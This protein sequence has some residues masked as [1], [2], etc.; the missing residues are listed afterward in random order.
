MKRLILI[1]L[2]FAGIT[3]SQVNPFPVNTFWKDSSGMIVPKNNKSTLYFK[4]ADTTAFNSKTLT[5]AQ[6]S[7]KADTSSVLWKDS[8]GVLIPKNNGTIKVGSFLYNDEMQLLLPDTV[9]AVNGQ[10]C[11]I[12]FDNV[13][14][15]ANW[16]NYRYDVICDSGIQYANRW[17]WTPAITGTVTL[18]LTINIY[19][20]THLVSTGNTV[21]KANVNS[22]IRTVLLTGNSLT[23]Q[24]TYTQEL[25]KLGG[26]LFKLLGTQGSTTNIV[27]IGDTI[28]NTTKHSSPIIIRYTPSSADTMTDLSL[29][30]DGEVVASSD[31]FSVLSTPLTSFHKNLDSLLANNETNYE[32]YGMLSKSVWDDSADKS[33]VDIP[34]KTNIILDPL[35]H[36]YFIWVSNSTI[37][38]YYDSSIVG[39][40]YTD[41]DLFRLEN[42]WY[43][44]FKSSHLAKITYKIKKKYSNEGRGGWTYSNY[45]NGVTSP[46]VLNGN[47][48]FG[49]YLTKYYYPT[50][51]H[52][53]IELGINDIFGC[54]DANIVATT[55]SILQYADSLVNSM[56]TAGVTTIGISYIM[57]PSFSQDAFASNYNTLYNTW[58]YKKNVHYFNRML[59]SHFLG[60][61]NVSLIPIQCNID[62]VNNMNTALTVYNA[63]NPNTYSMQ[64]NG[65]H[66]NAYGYWQMA[67]SY[68]SWLVNH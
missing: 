4:I 51:T 27:A 65:V 47:I 16:Q 44:F 34:L 53:I 46:Y 29:K 36:Y 23:A 9:Y 3:Y 60:V 22:G 31:T 41:A 57:P 14:L 40:Q 37:N 39:S 33:Y 56:R 13:I 26:T 19:S 52:S 67:D 28:V 45:E 25:F 18:T 59:K 6:L 32:T 62:V 8:S 12:Y 20:S 48:N 2:L 42:V 43:E 10:E 1:L 38:V 63:R 21:V 24:N 61:A 5:T 68:Y 58:Q 11:N 7:Y 15:A 49:N 66:P 55:T 64:N 54:T 30:M 35:K 50:I 17:S